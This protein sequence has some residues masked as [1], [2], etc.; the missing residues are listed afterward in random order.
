MNSN[1][2]LKSGQS[3]LSKV[4]LI[5][6][7]LIVAVAI[8]G[9]WI[10][11][12]SSSG[13]EKAASSMAKLM[14]DIYSTQTNLYKIQNMVSSNQ[15][16]KTIEKLADQQGAI[17]NEDIELL[18]KGLE[19]NISSEHKKFY[20]AL[21][22]HLIEYKKSVDR[23]TKLAPAGTGTPYLISAAERM[24]MMDQL[25]TELAAF[26]SRVGSPE[27]GSSM[28]FYIFLVIL[29]VL[30][31]ASVVVVLSIVKK[32][33]TDHVAAPIRETAG[34]LKEYANG[35]F[36]HVLNWDADDAM[37]ELVQSVN[38]LRTKLSEQASGGLKA[39]AA[40]AV[41]SKTDESPVSL[42]GMVKKSPEQE[43]LV[44]S[45]KKAIDKLQDI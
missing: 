19:S 33:M 27:L 38:V 24:D 21:S 35:R 43:S 36:S 5:L 18:K 8:F 2:N 23:F 25:L 15:D 4:M 12:P 7:I 32:V 31:A 17:L 11:Q 3:K 45:S 34:A 1:Y 42:S 10:N 16:K 6:I 37:G 13:G 30:L 9:L 20:S 26:E 39:A 40:R 22:T 41:S 29:I 28:K 44:T 14:K